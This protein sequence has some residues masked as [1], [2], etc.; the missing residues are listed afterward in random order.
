MA[1]EIE[2]SYIRKKMLIIYVY[3]NIK[4]SIFKKIMN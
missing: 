3:L 4:I 1:N 2:I